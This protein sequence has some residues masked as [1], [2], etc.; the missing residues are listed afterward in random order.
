MAGGRSKQ[1]PLYIIRGLLQITNANV[2]LKRQVTVQCT[3]KL[4]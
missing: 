4:L 1:V 3:V 2:A